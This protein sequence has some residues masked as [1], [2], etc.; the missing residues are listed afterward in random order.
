[1]EKNY[2]ILVFQVSNVSGCFYHLAS[3]LGL[4]PAQLINVYLGSSLRSMQDVLAD[5]STAVTG[6][7]VFSCQVRIFSEIYYHQRSRFFKEKNFEINYNADF[8]MSN[9][10]ADFDSSFINGLRRAKS[11]QRTATGAARS[12][13]RLNDW[14]FA[15]PSRWSGRIESCIG[16]PYSLI[17]PYLFSLLFRKILYRI[18]WILGIFNAQLRAMNYDILEHFF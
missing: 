18:E 4:L 1:M 5:K 11:S 3:A 8:W 9:V 2:E 16:K 6:Y 10:V 14:K 7:I 15:L 12:R 17:F 13:F